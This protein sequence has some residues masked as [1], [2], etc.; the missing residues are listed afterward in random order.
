MWDIVTIASYSLLG[1][2]T[3][4]AL[5]AF[6][7]KRN[8]KSKTISRLDKEH[9]EAAWESLAEMEEAIKG[10]DEIIHESEE[11]KRAMAGR[12]KSLVDRLIK[13]KA[14]SQALEEKA[15]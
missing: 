13:E 14:S 10:L 11:Y 7:V 8:L 5:I 15:S 6:A 9:D 4:A 2:L 1:A 3:V 12:A